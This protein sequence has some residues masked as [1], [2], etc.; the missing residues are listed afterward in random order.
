MV[1]QEKVTTAFPK[2][3]LLF[4]EWFK[5]KKKVPACGTIIQATHKQPGLAKTAVSV[6]P[7]VYLSLEVQ[8]RTQEPIRG[9]SKNSNGSRGSLHHLLKSR[10]QVG[11]SWW[12]PEG[13][14]KR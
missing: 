10:K 9:R 6:C 14:D 5:K 1:S 12:R 3:T 4:K 7:R 11:V 13:C 2:S 8:T